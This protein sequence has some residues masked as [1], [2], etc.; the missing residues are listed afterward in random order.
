MPTDGQT[1][2]RYRTSPPSTEL[3]NSLDVCRLE[4][5]CSFIRGRDPADILKHTILVD[6]NAASGRVSSYSAALGT[7]STNHCSLVPAVLN[8]ETCAVARCS[9]RSAMSH[10][11]WV[12]VR[13]AAGSN[14]S[15]S[16]GKSAA[17]DDFDLHA[18][19]QCSCISSRLLSAALPH[20][21]CFWTVNN[22]LHDSDRV[23]CGVAAG[24]VSMQCS[25]LA[26]S[27]STSVRPHRRLQTLCQ[28]RVHGSL[29]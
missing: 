15:P 16:P 20:S 10:H 17:M 2:G 12:A 8:Q 29:S 13:K 6:T 14:N 26:S 28:T 22:A 7:S 19:R 1:T 23:P 3:S 9:S 27:P 25:H 24:A 11:R 18:A 21:F 4:P 5:L